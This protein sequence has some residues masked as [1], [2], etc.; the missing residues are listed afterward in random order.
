MNKDTIE[1]LNKKQSQYDE[2]LESFSNES[3][4]K[5][6]TV[7][8]ERRRKV[9][10]NIKNVYGEKLD[11]ETI[12]IFGL[13]LQFEQDIKQ[14]FMDNKETLTHITDIAPEDMTESKILRSKNR[15]NN[16][17]TE[18]GDWVFASSS[19]VDG[20]NPYI[21][22]NS[23]DGMILIY[24]NT[25]IYGGDNI[26]VQPDEN[27]NKKVLLK[28]PNYIYKLNLENFRPVVTLKCQKDGKPFFEFSEEWI[29]DEDVDIK[30]PKQVLGI[31]KVTDITELIKNYQVFC[32]VDRRGIAM[33]IRRTPTQDVAINKLLSAIEDG[34]LRYINRRS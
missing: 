18:R 32:D 9:Q 2:L 25:Y 23:K 6:L 33:E 24:R 7:L 29:S 27:G 19:P 5:A 31:D 3:I 15:A 13:M 4:K 17:E 26:Q 11:D 21:A 10:Q 30:D 1:R 22:R 34:S 20:K 12:K 14:I 16:Y 8:E 28:D